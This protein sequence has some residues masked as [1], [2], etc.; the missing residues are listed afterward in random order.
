MKKT[1]T[2]FPVW[3]I[4]LTD[5]VVAL[6]T[7]FGVQLTWPTDPFIVL[8][9]LH[10]PIPVA[11]NY[12]LISLVIV[13]IWVF[14]LWQTGSWSQSILGAGPAEYQKV[15]RATL[16]TFLSIAL[17]S[18]LTK[19]EIARGYLLLT[20]PIGIVLLLIARRFWR[21]VLIRRRA[22][23][24]Y[25]KKAVVVGSVKSSDELCAK[26]ALHPEAG[27]TVVGAFLSQHS[28]P[29][30]ESQQLT[31][32]ESGVPIW[33]G[34]DD[35]LPVIRGQHIDSVI[36]GSADELSP[37]DVRK[38]GWE[39]MPRRENLYLAANIFD[40]A[41]PRL[42]LK[43]V[44][45]LSLIEV[46]E[47][48]LTGLNRFL[49]RAIDIVL[50]LVAL[51]LAIPLFI[52][53]AIAI[54]RFDGKSVFFVQERIGR[55]GRPFKMVKFRTMRV[56]AEREVPE[57]LDADHDIAGNTVLFKLKDDP[58]VTKPGVWLR[59]Y[60]IDELPQLLNVLVGQMS[61]VGPRPPLKS[62]VAQYDTHVKSR[63]LVK[64]GITGLWQISGRSDLS[65]EESVRADLSY[66]QNWSIASDLLILLRTIR[67]VVSGRGAY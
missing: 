24:R 10:L 1:R 48:Q 62:E 55:H 22:R 36:V 33:G 52:G 4:A 63:F 27:L 32:T 61:L 46:D 3:R 21:G 65:W 64:P 42:S 28:I 13:A 7:T 56:S 6:V 8:N 23:G 17:I 49:K 40:I 45:G 2:N 25:C 39:L 58:R 53:V 20:L 35:L 66:V 15:T 54:K 43:P 51:I 38:L 29:M 41:G 5:L 26:L 34:I 37:M 44:S 14:M 50:S 47:P 12:T 31:L 11:A 57:L 16:I 30:T 18:Y 9:T 60:S 19:A 59:R 67:V